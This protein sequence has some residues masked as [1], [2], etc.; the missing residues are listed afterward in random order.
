MKG[1]ILVVDDEEAIRKSLQ[2]IL[3]Y[4]GYDPVC[5]PSPEEALEAVRS[6]EPDLILLDI[7]MPRMDGMEVLSRIRK[8]SRVPVVMI[9]GHGTI[10]TAVEATKLGAFDFLEKPLERERVL[11]VL[12]NALNQGRLSEENRELRRRVDKQFEIIGDSP[13]MVSLREEIARAA[14]TS[15]TV[16]ITGE[17]GVG[18]ELVAREIHRLSQRNGKS[19]V[20]VNCAAI[21]E[22]L[23]E[24]ELFGHEKGAFTGATSRQIGKFVQ[25]DDGTILLDEIGDMSPRTQAKVLR[26]LQNGEVE[27]VGSPRTLTVDVRVLAATNHDL[28]AAIRE[29]KFREDLFFRL[30][31]IPVR[32]KPLRERRE[33]IPE[34]IRHFGEAICRENQFRMKEFTAAAV[35]RLEELPWPGNVR[36][37]R[38]AVE[39]LVIMGPAER[40]DAM[41]VEELLSV[42]QEDREEAPVGSLQE[43]RESA[44]RK[45]LLEKLRENHWNISKTARA[46]GTPRSNLYKKLEQYGIK[47][48]PVT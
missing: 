18:K 23:I 41:D 40:I 45:F 48:E 37:L 17:S 15:A 39:R 26:V 9:S 24:S 33:D 16:L 27:P 28:E 34:L 25:A 38:N 32:C 10:T 12:R 2:R 29:G 1:R 11:L 8:Q 5:V 36:E 13:S 30:N 3:K 7:K 19:F 31:V 4:E 44:E 20:Q 42:L 47:K 6:A 14:P 46:I 22:E 35:R 43:I 21:P